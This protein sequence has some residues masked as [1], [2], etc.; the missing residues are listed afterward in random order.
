MRKS[1]DA[2]LFSLTHLLFNVE[3]G[4]KDLFENDIEILWKLYL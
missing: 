2:S 4:W 3:V 1:F